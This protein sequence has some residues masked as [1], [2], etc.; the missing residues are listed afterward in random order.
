MTTL[1]FPQSGFAM[2]LSFNQ[3]T[4]SRNAVCHFQAQT[5]KKKKVI[6]PLFPLT[7]SAGGCNDALVGRAD[8]LDGRSLGPQ[9]NVKKTHQ[10]REKHPS[11]T[12]AYTSNKILLYS[13]I[14]HLVGL[15]FTTN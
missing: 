13:T 5:L 3:Q 15:F 1:C 10:T 2:W 6:P 12:L 11:Q 14:I 4:M 9:V 7:L 8:P